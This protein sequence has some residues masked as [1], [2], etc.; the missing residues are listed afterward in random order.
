VTKGGKFRRSIARQVGERPSDKHVKKV[1]ELHGRGF[2]YRLI[3]R[4]V[5]LSTNT[6]MEIVQRSAGTVAGA[7]ATS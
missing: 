7:A 3:G 2:S 5:G 4:D 1:L 6:V